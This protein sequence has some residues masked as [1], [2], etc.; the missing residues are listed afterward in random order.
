MD[1][2]TIDTKRLQLRNWVLDDADALFKYASDPRVSEL[3]LWPCHTSVE[4][5]RD[6]IDKFFITNP[7]NFAI[8]L[9]ETNEPIG[10]IGFVPEGEEHYRVLTNEREVG[11]WIGFP[12]WNKGLT[13]EALEA[14]IIC[15]RDS[16][17]LNSLLITIDDMN[18][19]SQ[20]VAGKCGFQLLEYYHHNETL[21]KAYRLNLHT[22]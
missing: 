22:T 2:K 1:N 18:T 11:Y 17:G 15:C 8:V 16:I 20:R 14:L 4:M 13:T 9:K 6:V 21:S 12:Y 19:A 5:S 7:Y 3:A 10:C